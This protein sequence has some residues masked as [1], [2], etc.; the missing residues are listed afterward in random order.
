M[1]TSLKAVSVLTLSTI[2]TY[3]FHDFSAHINKYNS[4][5]TEYR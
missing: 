1:S 4:V 2:C 5:H 3:L